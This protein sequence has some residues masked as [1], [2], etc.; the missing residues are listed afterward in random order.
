M[1]GGLEIWVWSWELIFSVFGIRTEVGAGACSEMQVSEL[2]EGELQV[3]LLAQT[4]RDLHQLPRRHQFENISPDVH[5][6]VDVRRRSQ[7][8]DVAAHA[9]VQTG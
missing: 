5:P 2:R 9:L 6:P 8:R 3:V 4:R 1:E 7:G